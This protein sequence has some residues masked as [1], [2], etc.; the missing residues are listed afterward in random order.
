[1]ATNLR[2]IKIFDP[3]LCVHCEQAY[4]ADVT[5]EDG[6]KKKMFYCSRRD[7][8]NWLIERPVTTTE[9]ERETG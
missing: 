5:L 4:I 6:R 2:I 9:T 8:D 1:M 3:A 7:C